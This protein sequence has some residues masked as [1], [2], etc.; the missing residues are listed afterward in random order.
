M[1]FQ[2]S[3]M[4]N[5]S[6]FFK[7]AIF[8]ISAWYFQLVR[9]CE[10]RLKMFEFD[11]RGT[12]NKRNTYNEVKSLEVIFSDTRKRQN[13]GFFSFFRFGRYQRPEPHHCPCVTLIR[14]RKKLYFYFFSEFGKVKRKV[15]KSYW[16]VKKSKQN[17]APFEKV[18]TKVKHIEK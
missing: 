9:H 16:K 15:K 6:E 2:F 18:K 10:H 8:H 13:N 3:K 12:Q 4:H 11:L 14:V 1:Q 7:S 5:F 17:S